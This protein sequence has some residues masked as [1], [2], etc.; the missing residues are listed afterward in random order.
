MEKQCKKL[1]CCV[2][3][4]YDKKITDR[5]SVAMTLPQTG[6]KGIAT[7]L[8]SNDNSGRLEMMDFTKN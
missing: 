5:K 3:R 2:K 4:K 7:S 6:E 8:L 1:W